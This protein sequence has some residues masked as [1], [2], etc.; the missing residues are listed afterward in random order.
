MLSLQEIRSI[1]EH[2]RD[3]KPTT[4]QSFFIAYYLVMGP[5]LILLALGF[6]IFKANSISLLWVLGVIHCGLS[7]WFLKDLRND[8]VCAKL[9]LEALDHQGIRL[10]WIYREHTMTMQGT[11]QAVTLHFCF[12]NKRHGSISG[13]YDRITELMSFFNARYPYISSGYSD[14]LGKQFR[15]SP[16][17]LAEHPQRLG[18]IK[19]VKV[20]NSQANGW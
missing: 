10:V 8:K 7:F 16:A 6:L 11:F 15:K 18:E 12:E 4:F 17:A 1:F 2:Q 13:T 20:D 3:H 14:A 19:I 9:M 5:G